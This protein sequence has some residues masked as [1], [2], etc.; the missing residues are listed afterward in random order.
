MI[1]YR[2]ICI[3]KYTYTYG[4]YAYLLC[5]CIFIVRM[6]I[7]CAYAYSMYVYVFVYIYTR[8]AF[9]CIHTHASTTSKAAK[10]SSKPSGA[11]TVWRRRGTGG[12]SIV[13]AVDIALQGRD[14]RSQGAHLLALTVYEKSWDLP[15]KAIKSHQNPLKITIKPF[16]ASEKR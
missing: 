7:Y 15:L 4:A 16:K 3:H 9:V 1:L 10:N 8:T 13:E 14:L 5:V 2:C 11:K 6:H 12:A